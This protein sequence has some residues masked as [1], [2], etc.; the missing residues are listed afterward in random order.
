MEEEKKKLIALF[1]FGVIAGLIGYTK[2]DQGKRE[3][4]IK[5]LAQQEWEIPCSGRSSISRSTIRDWLRRL[6]AQWQET[7]EPVPEGPR[8]RRRGAQHRSRDRVGTGQSQTRTG[9]DVVVS[10]AAGGAPPQPP[11]ARLRGLT[12]EHLPVVPTPWSAPAAARGAG[13][14]ALRGGTAQRLVASG[15]HARPACEKRREAAQVVPVRLHR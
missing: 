11:A 13:P 2:L 6:R 5:E 12:A 4:R 3:A 1:R 15:L 14:A 8:R 7:G 9:A 10:G